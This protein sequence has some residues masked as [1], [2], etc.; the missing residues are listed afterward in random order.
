[1]FVESLVVVS[2]GFFAETKRAPMYQG[3]CNRCRDSCN[4]ISSNKDYFPSAAF[5]TSLLRRDFLR[6][7]VFFLMMF[8]STALSRLL[9]ASLSSAWAVLRSLAFTASRVFFMAPLTTPFTALFL[10]VFRAVTRI[11]FL[12]EFLIG[13]GL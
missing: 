10:S 6:A 8:F 2:N 3:S 5:L 4:R 12:A 9:I 7:A 11:Y 1:M 13:I